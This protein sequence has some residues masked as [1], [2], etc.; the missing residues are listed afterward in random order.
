M[1]KI[2]GDF[3]GKGLKPAIIV[4]RFNEFITY[5]LLDGALDCLKRHGVNEEDI[6]IVYVPGGFEL[7]LVAKK[8]AKTKKYDFIIALAAII[9]GETPHFDFVASENAKG[10]A[11]AS[12]E[13]EV[14]IIYGV[15]TTETTEE[16]IERAGVKS[17][18]K[19]W[20]A[21]LAGIEMANLLKVISEGK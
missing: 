5:K 6:T 13:T 15:L 21:A 4:S 10:I 20:Q 2:E 11:H 12:M 14:P 3:S 18:N 1:K 17:G 9:R 19:G 8:L 7:P 16:A